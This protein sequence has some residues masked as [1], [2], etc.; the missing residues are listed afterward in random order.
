MEIQQTAHTK[1]P[2]TV[3]VTE[4]VTQ[5]VPVLREL[6]ARTEAVETVAIKARVEA[7]LMKMEFKEGQD[8]TKDQVL[9]RLDDRTYVAEL[10]VA[11]ARFAQAQASLKLA[12]EQVSVRAAEAG[13]V[14]ARATLKKAVQDVSR[15]RP[16]AEKDAVP[17]QDLDTALAAEEVAQ[18]SVQAEEAR[19]T[20]SIIQ[21][22]VGILF[23][24][25]E[26]QAAQGAVD[27]AELNLD[28]C[29]IYS[30][31]D[32]L[33]G[34]TEVS[35]G[36]LVGRGDTPTLATVSSK[37]PIY[38]TF[39][40]SEDEYLRFTT[41][42]EREREKVDDAVQLILADNS[43]FPYEGVVV[44]AGRAVNEKTG[45][46]QI[47]AEFSNP[48]GTLRPGQFGRARIR[49]AIMEN[50]MLI[51]QRAVMERQSAKVVFIVGSDNKVAQRTVQLGE[52]FEG[53]FVVIKGLKVG[54]RVISEGQLK[55]RPGGTVVPMDKPITSEPGH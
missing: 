27:L 16:L 5:T 41:K 53:K 35:V 39:A 26:V 9:Y 11:E 8:V 36:N 2:P 46:L 40:I 43:V 24:A 7:V 29:T 50:A 54:D 32:G 14:S 20:N 28:Y 12:R 3:V 44:T 51:P 34:R 33:I 23:A 55:A 38:V 4:V 10:A 45:T 52:R 48:E 25:A 13:V 47:V 15:L 19:L 22:K 6:V 1:A 21:E 49:V 42:K 18:A 37:N 17:R 31:L 30:P